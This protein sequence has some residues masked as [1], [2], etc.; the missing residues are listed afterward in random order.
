MSL[1]TNS[2]LQYFFSGL[3]KKF[4]PLSHK[5]TKSDITDFPAS[6]PA[7]GGNASTVNGHTVNADV[8]AEAK[9][10]DT[11]TWRGVQDNLTSTA[12]DQSLS[13]NQGKVLK[14]LVDSKAAG[15]HT[16]TSVND[17]GDGGATTFAYSKAGLGFGDYTWLAAWNGKELRAVAK[18]QFAQASHTHDDRY[19]TESEID[20]K[21]KAKA[22]AHSHPY[23]PTAGGT[24]G[25]TAMIS[26]PDTGNWS[27]N[28]SGVTFPVKRGGL[29]W[30]GQSDGVSL[31]AE[32][33]GN[34]NLELILQFS[35]DDS[36]G[37]TIRNAKGNTVSRLTASGTFTGKASTAGTADNATKVNGHTVNSDVPSGA[38]FTDT[39]YS[40]A[41]SSNLGLVKTGSN[42][43]NSGGTISLT[44]ANVTTALGYTPPTTDTKYGN[45]T[46][47]SAGLMSSTDKKKLDGV[48]MTNTCMF[49]GSS[50]GT[51]EVLVTCDYI[52]GG[53]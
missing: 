21:L 48:D 12:T 42:I 27:N 39:T 38:K 9:F 25:G 32:E 37:L 24:M 41:S 13:A 23:L 5:H 22:D 4:A 19:Y 18:S 47:S 2:G 7:N 49:D 28:N 51:A 50:T 46:Q 45:A 16:H 10:T 52:D 15:N 6:L 17:I 14:A 30:S 43:T 1:V 44:K 8:P 11:N 29:S 34:D 26:W 53:A 20:T 35:D 3:K 40:A 33:T 31:Y 36:N